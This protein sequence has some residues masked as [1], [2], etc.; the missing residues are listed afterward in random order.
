M[1]EQSRIA[2]PYAQAIFELAQEADALEQWSAALN[3]LSELVEH[4]DLNA[5]IKDPRI[6]KR[7]LLSI[8][9]QI[10]GDD[11][12]ELTGNL[13]RLL[14]QNRRLAYL[15]FIARQYESLR[16]EAEGVIEAELETAFPIDEHYEQV[17]SD[18]LEN[19]FG[20][21][22]RL[23]CA[24]ND[25]LIGGAVIRAGDWVVDGSLRARLNKLATALGV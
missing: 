12:D 4:P 18:A 11:I 21:K 17:V 6:T 23:R 8:V 3:D 25:D 2:R 14:V 5:V 22:I 15:P 9:L 24:V 16:A 7:Q 10:T 13:I 1:S 19:R 20:Q